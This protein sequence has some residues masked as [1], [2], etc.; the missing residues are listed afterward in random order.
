MTVNAGE[1]DRTERRS[2]HAAPDA[3]RRRGRWFAAF[4]VVAVVVATT[5]WAARDLSSG[6][7]SADTTTA[8]ERSFA[9]VQRTDLVETTEYDGTLGRLLGDDVSVRRSG[10]VTALPAEGSTVGQGDAIAWIDNQ[11][12]VLLLGDLP[13]WRA[14]MSDIEGPDVTQLET[15][16]TALGYNEDEARMTVDDNFTSATEA[17]VQDWQTSIGAEDDGVV[18]LGEVVFLPAPVVIDTLQVEVGDVIAEGAPIFTTSAGDVK[19]T[20]GLPTTEQ[21]AIDVGTVVTVTLPDEST[22]EGTVTDVAS[23]ATVSAD[24]NQATYDVT[25]ELTDPTVAAG[26]EEAPVTVEVVTDRADG[27]LAVPIQALVALAEGGYAVEVETGSGTELVAV[28]PGFYSN[29]LIEVD[30]ALDTDGRVVV[31]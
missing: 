17:V 15:A 10:T 3:P 30:G 22:T 9:D 31:P 4:V 27:V 2:D 21:D 28:E 12:I 6:A 7:E 26:I 11:P 18:D 25:V 20:F 1:Q 14:I 29:G 16:L 8:A 19:V 23:V 24:T 13:A 5:M